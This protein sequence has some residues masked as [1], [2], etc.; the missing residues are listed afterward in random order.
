MANTFEITFQQTCLQ[1]C[2]RFHGLCYRN[3]FIL[4]FGNLSQSKKNSCKRYFLPL[5][6]AKDHIP[7]ECGSFVVQT[8]TS[9]PLRHTGDLGRILHS[10][11]PKSFPAFFPNNDF[12][13][14]GDATA[15]CI[16]F[17]FSL[18]QLF[19]TC[20]RWIPFHKS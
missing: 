16:S 11:V 14:I 8:S 15:K 17:N 4:P 13:F 12:F 5:L 1:H 6:F 18:F 3:G 9:H 19:R 2:H 20:L 10:L 7:K